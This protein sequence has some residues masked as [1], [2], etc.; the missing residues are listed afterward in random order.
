M[1]ENH[2][3]MVQAEVLGVT[4]NRKYLILNINGVE[5]TAKRNFLNAFSMSDLRTI[6]GEPEEPIKIPVLEPAVECVDGN[7]IPKFVQVNTATLRKL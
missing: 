3:H 1:A 2:R 5:I 4:P 6:I 7:R